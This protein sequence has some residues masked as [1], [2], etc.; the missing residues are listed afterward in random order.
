MDGLPWWIISEES[1][2]NAGDSGLIPRL[3][4]SPEG[5]NGYHSSI[6]AWEIPWKKR[7]WWATV[8]G[9]T[10]ELNMT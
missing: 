1:A 9:V 6:L 5:G 2:C 8:H 7:A 4:R 3:E 10:K